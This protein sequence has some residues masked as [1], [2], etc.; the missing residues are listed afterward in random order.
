MSI[1]ISIITLIISIILPLI[2]YRQTKQSNLKAEIRG[3]LKLGIE[4]VNNKI[5]KIN[6]DYFESQKNFKFNDCLQWLVNDSKEFKRSNKLSENYQSIFIKHM[7]VV[8]SSYYIHLKYITELLKESNY[9]IKE[10]QS[11][12]QIYID[13]MDG[14]LE[15]LV[16]HEINFINALKSKNEFEYFCE[17]NFKIREILIEMDII[18]GES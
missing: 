18:P 3:H 12:I 6:Q 16:I 13:S 10:K 9:K 15:Y 17:L 11:I 4:N 7:E 8:Y 2:V 14:Q 1:W 5:S